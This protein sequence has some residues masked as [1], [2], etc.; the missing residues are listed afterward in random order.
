[1]TSTDQ[2]A[3]AGTVAQTPSRAHV[4]ASLSSFFGSTIEWY[5]YFL[6]GT[7]AALVFP[8]VFFNN[9]PPN[10]AVLYSMVTFA[11]AFGIRPLGALVFGHFGD[12]IGRKP[13]LIFTLIAMSLCTGLIGVLPSYDAIGITAPVILIILRAIQGFALGGEWGGASLMAVEHAPAGKRGLYGS[14]VQV[15]VPAGLLLSSAAFGAVS[16]MGDDQFFSWGWRIPFLLSFVLAGIGLYI[17]LSVSEPEAFKKVQ[18]SGQRVRVPFLEVLKNDKKKT[19]VLILLQTVCNVGYFTVTVFSVTFITTELGL[20]RTLATTGLLIAAA[21]DF[22]AQPLF[23]MLSDKIG[24]K[25][26]YGIGTVFLAAF[27]FPFFLLLQSG[28]TILIWVALAL[29][30]GIGHAA[31]GSV[32]SVIYAEQYPARYRYTGASF[33]YQFAGVIS[34]GPTPII[35]AALVSATGSS[36]GVSVFLIV[37]AVIS[38]ICLF[39]MKET[40]KETLS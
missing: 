24:R 27:A 28:N 39:L 12:R 2:G 35:A 10:V 21:V 34:S 26:V 25:K 8:Q 16:A 5:D 32:L 3:I 6:F 17:R 30:L 14:A 11:L 13:L 38:L 15:G 29:G 20:P 23:G 9:L 7:A 36:I 33:S 31:T 19:I 40:Y 4:R 22:V 37:A 1:M 18:E